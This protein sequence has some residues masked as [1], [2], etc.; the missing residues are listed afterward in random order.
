MESVMAQFVVR[1]LDDEVTAALKRRARMHGRSMEEEVRQI[2]RHAIHEEPSVS[3]AL[4]TRMA[5]RFAWVGL[6]QPLPELRGQEVEGMD[7]AP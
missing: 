1:N 2:L 4:G 6:D 5:A 3:A 7:V